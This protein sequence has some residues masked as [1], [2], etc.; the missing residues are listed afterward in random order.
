MSQPDLPQLLPNNKHWWPGDLFLAAPAALYHCIPFHKTLILH[1]LR[2]NSIV[3]REDKDTTPVVK[4]MVDRDTTQED[5]VMVD[6]EMVDKA[7]T[8]EEMGDKAITQ[9]EMV[10]KAITQEEEEMVD[11]A[12]TQEEEMVDKAT[13]QEEEMVVKATTQEEEMVVKATTQEDKEM[14]DKATTQE[15]EADRGIIQEARGTSLELEDRVTTLEV[16]AVEDWVTTREYLRPGLD[17]TRTS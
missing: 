3:S 16:G 7:I 1:I 10:D 14:V 2:N 4:A 11:K 8:Q 17:S 9:E 12:T 13:T 15:E 6:R 5:R